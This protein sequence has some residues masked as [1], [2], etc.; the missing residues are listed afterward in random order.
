MSS[1]EADGAAAATIPAPRG[2]RLSRVLLS[3]PF[4]AVAVAIFT[5]P[6]YS[7][8]PSVGPDPSWIAGLYMAPGE[9]LQFGTQFVFTYG[10]LGFLEKPV[11]YGEAMWMAS[12]AY[13]SLIHVGL[14]I[15]VLALARR[16]LPLA[17]A[18]AA[19]Y[20][21][22]VV[23]YLDA[24]VVLLALLCCLAALDR[25]P[26][27]LA[28]PLV[29]YGGAVVG[30]IE[31][32]G[33]ANF[34]LAVLALC[35]IT[36]LSLDHRRRNL[37]RFAALALASLLVLWLLAGQ[38]LWNLPDFAANGFQ[39]ISGYSGAMGA[40]LGTMRW[41]LPLAGLAAALLVAGAVVATRGEATGRRIALPT[42]L[43]LFA[44]LAF[45]QGFVRQGPATRAEFFVL[46]LGAG[47]GLAALL[48]PR[49]PQLPRGSSA[50]ALVLPLLALTIVALPTSSFWRSLEPSDHTTFLREDLDAFLS[51]GERD[52]IREESRAAMRS[53][54]RLDRRMLALL[55]ERS[56]HVD[57]WEIG[58][59]WAYGLDWQPLPAIQDYEAYTPA[60]DRLNAGA[61]SGSRGPETILRQNTRALAAGESSIDDRYV[62]W[63]S[64]VAKLAMLC[65]YRALQT[66]ERWQLLGR[67]PDRCG[68]ERPL[69]T[70]AA[71]TGEAIPVPAP[72]GPDQIVFAR[73]DGLG[74]DGWERL[75]S[76]AY[77][78]RNRTVAFDPGASWRLVP[79]TADD[80]LILRAPATID[81]PRPF[82]L[83]PG[84]DSFAVEVDGGGARPVRVEFFSQAIGPARAGGLS[85]PR[86]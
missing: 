46:M 2:E 27:R 31:L 66:T 1:G 49:L 26:P 15:A 75:R 21:L 73:I 62:G 68:A 69:R 24:A 19:T 30:A 45:K 20:V 42:L 29:V 54:Y 33:K 13:Q 65:H 61:L 28:L 25:E 35:T 72:P 5:W 81:F 74:V 7:I 17:V 70:V 52:R 22:L 34:G 9:G 59:A 18:L 32:L 3:T 6:I 85:S 12:F 51:A 77:R 36:L 67:T 4:L 71:E 53:S 10:P 63:E 84:A 44:F 47:I 56:V 78:A 23:G 39:V 80:G 16:A 11:L 41:E 37:P 76:F 38:S 57:P 48:P 79:A 14:A 86:R 60:L 40:D 83:A 58:V 55:R 43:A 50:L 8:H 82:Q 64:P